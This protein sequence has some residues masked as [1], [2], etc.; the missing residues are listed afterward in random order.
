MLMSRTNGSP[1]SLSTGHIDLGGYPG[2]ML[3]LC[4]FTAALLLT[5]YYLCTLYSENAK[6]GF[7]GALTIWLFATIGLS[8]RPQMVGY[9]LLL[10]E[11]L[12]LHLGR[13]WTPRWFLGLPPLFALW[14]NC[15][16]SFF[17]GIIV[18]GVFLFSSLFDFQKG[19]LVALP[20]QPH[21]RRMLLVAFILSIAALFLNPIGVRQT[22]YP[23]VTMF[24]LPVNLSQVDEWK[25]LQFGDAR[26]LALLG[27]LACLLLLVLRR[28]TKLFWHEVLL[29]VFASWAALSHRRLL[30]IFGILAAPVLSRAVSSSWQE[31]SAH[32]DRPALNAVF[33]VA[34][35]LS[36]WRAFPDRKALTQQVEQKSPTKAV[37]FMKTHHLSGR[38]L[39]EYSFGGYLIWEAPEYPVF[40]DGRGDIFEATGV[41]TEFGDWATLQ[42]DPH[43]LLDRYGIEFCVLARQAPMVR[44]LPLLRSWTT[45]YA[46][47]NAVIFVRAADGSQRPHAPAR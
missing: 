9:L 13:T 21:A 23:L 6:T 16:G 27:V 25:P 18:A 4:F 39:N 10:V 19:P 34:S 28:R 29:L 46:D 45:V 22:A 1:S 12:L 37:E 44:V 35:L 30:F 11:L 2:L 26:S 17:L 7:G 33:L 15:H 20:W 5:G 36:V 3:W 42:S 14:V 40:V 24:D 8:V 32:R 41:L 31:Y 38:M 47:E 43:T